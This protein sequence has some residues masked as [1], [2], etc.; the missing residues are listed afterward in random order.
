[1]AKP[2]IKFVD[3]ECFVMCDNGEKCVC[4]GADRTQLETIKPQLNIRFDGPC[5]GGDATY[6]YQIVCRSFAD[7][8]EKY[9]ACSCCKKLVGAKGRWILDEYICEDC[10]QDYDFNKEAI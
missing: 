3:V 8:Y 2:I 9:E 7:Y 4:Q 1:M 10:Q 6:E 5:R